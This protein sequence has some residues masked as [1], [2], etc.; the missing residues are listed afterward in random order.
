MAV[1]Q[2]RTRYALL[3]GGIVFLL[4]LLW[5]FS[6]IVAY[7]LISAILSL[8][9]RP[10]VRS[11]QQLRLGRF[12]M[13][14]SLSAL[15]TLVLMWILLAGLLGFLFPLLIR[16]FDQLSSIDP[17]SVVNAI[18]E[19]LRRLMVY[20]GNE[21]ARSDSWTLMDLLKEQLSGKLKFSQL[22]EVFAFV[23]GTLGNLLVALFSISFISFFFLRDE[24]M[25]RDGV[26][27]F[28]PE[29]YEERVFRIMNSVQNLLKRYFIGLMAQ[30]FMVGTL[31]TIGL[32]IVGIGFGH[33][34]VIGVFFGLFNII[35][36]LGPWM[37]ALVGLLVAVAL[38]I[39]V[40]FMRVTFPLLLLMVL[41][42]AAVQLIDN[43]LFQPLIY[44]S[45]VKAH[46]L[47]IFLV[48][49]MSGTFAG[50]AGMIMAIPVYTI[51][52]VLAKEFFADY[53]LV[54]KLTENL[55]S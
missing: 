11:V 25:F 44:S 15:L 43:I 5:Y 48:I 3:A 38:H 14:K 50:I 29:E 24:N 41:V 9:A 47:E 49:L 4:F 26:L 31:V 51:L 21:S 42:F 19:P 35:P 12:R 53:K 54:K 23:A 2:K 37:G 45:S 34:V 20:L 32:T 1:I 27:L 22:T 36:Y 6:T 30:V 39:Q 17:Q 7:I 40:D 10:V 52:R 46:P 8:I 16:E 33:A 13:G 18:E 28:V 55:S